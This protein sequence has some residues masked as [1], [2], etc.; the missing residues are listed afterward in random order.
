MSTDERI[1]IEDLNDKA[2]NLYMGFKNKDY[3]YKGN[4]LSGIYEMSNDDTIKSRMFDK[5]SHAYTNF[6]NSS[7]NPNSEI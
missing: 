5:A 1:K 4:C 7:E 6:E 3:Y 2:S